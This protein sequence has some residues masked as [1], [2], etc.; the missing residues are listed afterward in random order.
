MCNGGGGGGGVIV[1]LFQ[2]LL[3]DVAFGG[4]M[5]WRHCG[6]VSRGGRVL[7]HC[8]VVGVERGVVVKR[9]GGGKVW[10]W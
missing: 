7:T 4:S 10:W 5:W 9:G 8:S 6:V 2:V 3:C 1:S